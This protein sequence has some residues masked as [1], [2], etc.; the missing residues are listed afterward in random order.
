MNLK[1]HGFTL[2]WLGAGFALVLTGSLAAGR[3]CADT[4][5]GAAAQAQLQRHLAIRMRLERER[6]QRDNEGRVLSG[7]G[8]GAGVLTAADNPN[9]ATMRATLQQTLL[10]Q[11][12]TLKCNDI[13]VENGAGS[14]VVVC[15]S[16]TGSVKST[17]TVVGG[18]VVNLGGGAP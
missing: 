13:E 5:D 17:R 18:D 8:S 2:T 16:D 4:I 15:G 11:G 14:V 10:Q 9:V 6:A 12:D 7:V 3:A 1:L